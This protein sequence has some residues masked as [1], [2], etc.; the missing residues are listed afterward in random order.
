M[1]YLFGDST[2]SALDVNFIQYL[3]DLAETGPLLLQ[4]EQQLQAEAARAADRRRA[5][6]A[7]LA[8]VEGLSGLV[9][10]TLG[11]AATSADSPSGRCAGAILRSAADLVKAEAER[12]RTAFADALT[13]M[14]AQV[15]KE[16]DACAK[17]LEKL[18]LKQDLVGAKPSLLLQLRGGTRFEARLVQAAPYGVEATIDLDV[19][20]AHVFSKPV[21]LERFVEHLEVET[22]EGSWLSKETKMRP[23]RFDKYHLLE[24]LLGADQAV[25]KLRQGPDGSGRGFDLK[26]RRLP[27]QASLLRV[28]D[29]PK[30]GEQPSELGAADAAKFMAL[31][32]ALAAAASDLGKSRRGLVHVALDGK[33]LKDLDRPSE[34]LERLVTAMT[35]VIQEIGRRSPSPNE[36]VL[37]RLVGDDR[38]E[39]IFLSKEDFRK[40]VESSSPAMLRVLEPLGLF[41]PAPAAAPQESEPSDPRAQA[42]MFHKRAIARMKVGE[43][44]A[45]LSDF[46]RAIQARPD[47]AEAYVNRASA[48]QTAGAAADAVSDL[49]TALRVAPT[50]WKY[51]ERIEHLLEVARQQ[52]KVK[53]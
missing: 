16:R 32:D 43:T 45:A 14:E 51:R 9:Q 50:G 41:R 47:F 2:P 10:R 52:A 22:A 40:K 21:R 17:A 31:A 20:P 35:P 46:D 42:E 49:E 15:A 29:P 6:D 19:P 5:A 48:R 7:E 26:V 3:R 11:D 53:T 28:D 38:R 8:K 4:A 12:S 34:I 44:A 37:K 25:L 13:K 24:A 39:E 18:L 27:A 23:H 36:L 1:A 30:A 33:G